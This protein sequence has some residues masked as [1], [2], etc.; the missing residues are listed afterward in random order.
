MEPQTNLVRGNRRRSGSCRWREP[1]HDPNLLLAQEA[2]TGRRDFIF[3]LE[4]PATSMT[5]CN[6]H[7]SCR[8]SWILSVFSSIILALRLPF[9]APFSAPFGS[10][11]T[12]PWDLGPWDLGSLA[13]STSIPIV[14]AADLGVISRS[15]KKFEG[16]G[17]HDP[18]FGPTAFTVF[19]ERC[20]FLGG[21]CW[22]GWSLDGHCD[23]MLVEVDAKKS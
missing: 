11:V 6:I 12:C 17:G 20:V 23:M 10:P 18:W 7:V 22:R 14:K 1:C 19:G 16:K 3:F 9:S 2:G 4:V 15:A 8:Y 13:G 21:H 5:P